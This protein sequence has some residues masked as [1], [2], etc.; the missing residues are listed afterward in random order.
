MNW[1]MS[2]I[3]RMA[4]GR[5]ALGRLS[6]LQRLRT[7]RDAARAAGAGKEGVALLTVVCVISSGCVNP[8]PGTESLLILVLALPG[9][10]G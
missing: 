3:A 1:P 6:R 4:P 9:K 2:T 5:I 8:E 10:A 7:G